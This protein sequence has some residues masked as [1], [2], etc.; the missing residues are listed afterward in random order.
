MG[1]SKKELFNMLNM[2]W[3]SRETRSWQCH[4]P[5]KCPVTRTSLH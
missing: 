1:I 4:L 3:L 5:R 2:L